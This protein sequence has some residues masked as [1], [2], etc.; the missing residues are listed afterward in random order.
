MDKV[1]ENFFSTKILNFK[2]VYTYNQQQ[3]TEMNPSEINEM[4]TQQVEESEV[5][6]IPTFPDHFFFSPYRS[7][8][9]VSRS[10]RLCP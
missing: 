6:K 3:P 4:P 10:S 8:T 2:R 9:K 5:R 1:R 7:S